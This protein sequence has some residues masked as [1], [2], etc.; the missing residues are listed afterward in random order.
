M[1]IKAG[2]TQYWLCFHLPYSSSSLHLHSLLIFMFWKNYFTQWKTSLQTLH[3]SWD[4]W[5]CWYILKEQDILSRE[6]ILNTFLGLYLKSYLNP[7]A[8]LV[9]IPKDE[10]KKEVLNTSYTDIYVICNF[11]FHL[12]S[13]H[14]IFSISMILHSLL[15]LMAFWFWYHVGKIL[16]STSATC[17]KIFTEN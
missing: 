12:I 13:F 6:S 17:L 5:N 16:V 15:Y 14:F 10:K 4:L 11:W 1:K 2:I 9:R 3:L 8:L 7:S